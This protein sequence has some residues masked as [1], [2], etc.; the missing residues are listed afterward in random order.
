MAYIIVAVSSSFLSY[1]TESL[2]PNDAFHSRRLGKPHHGI[3][4][5]N[6]PVTKQQ[7]KNAR[8]IS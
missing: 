7:L 1:M 8:Q 6:F 2:L 3:F 4:T 5:A